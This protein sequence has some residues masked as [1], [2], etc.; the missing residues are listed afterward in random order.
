MGWRVALTGRA[1][2]AFLLAGRIRRGIRYRRGAGT[3]KARRVWEDS[4]RVLVVGAGA[5][6]G[7]F[8]G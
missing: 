2:R 5:L 8:G 6:G 1:P 3:Q 4:M 7:Y